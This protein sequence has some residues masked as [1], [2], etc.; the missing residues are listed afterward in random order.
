MARAL[1]RRDPRDLV[2][3]QINNARNRS[4]YKPNQRDPGRA[5]VEVKN[6]LHIPHHSFSRGKDKRE[7]C[8]Y[9]KRN[10]RNNIQNS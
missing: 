6:A 2:G 3:D 8:G 7:V 9:A 5:D 10:Y 1:L 4:D